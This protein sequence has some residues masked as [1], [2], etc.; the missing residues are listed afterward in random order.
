MEYTIV[1]PRPVYLLSPN[2]RAHWS[3][4]CKARRRA[5]SAAQIL[6][7]AEWGPNPPRWER[8]EVVCDWIMPTKAYHPDPDNAIASLKAWR[9]GFADW[10]IV[11]NDKQLVPVWGTMKVSKLFEWRGEAWPRGCVVLTFR[12][13]KA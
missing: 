7:R 4:V 11:K 8:A 5:R 2:A 1:I 10:G 12:E 13:V 6:A 3:S 9:D